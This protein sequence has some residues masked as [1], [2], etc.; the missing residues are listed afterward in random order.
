MSVWRGGF[1][2]QAVEED[3]PDASFVT[4]QRTVACGGLLSHDRQKRKRKR[5]RERKKE[6]ERTSNERQGEGDRERDSD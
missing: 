1:R 4:R 6:R 5:E 3:A 2:L